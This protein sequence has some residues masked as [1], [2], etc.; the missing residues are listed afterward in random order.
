MFFK[1][2]CAIELDYNKFPEEKECDTFSQNSTKHL[3][4]RNLLILPDLMNLAAVYR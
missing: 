3:T 2:S 4:E 1:L